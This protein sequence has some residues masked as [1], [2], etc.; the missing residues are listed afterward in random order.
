MQ[1]GQLQQQHKEKHNLRKGGEVYRWEARPRKVGLFTI[2]IASH[3]SL[4]KIKKLEEAK[5]KY[6]LLD[7][8]L[9]Y[10]A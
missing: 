10:P 7:N 1:K 4:K 6:V 8:W 9:A 2:F 3:V 5:N